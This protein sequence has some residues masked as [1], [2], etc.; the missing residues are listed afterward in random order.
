MKL[1][2][3]EEPQL[4]HDT[5]SPAHFLSE[6]LTELGATAE[7]ILLMYGGTSKLYPSV[8]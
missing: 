2:K 1:R 7:S 5:L 8:R 4:N 3:L 6:I